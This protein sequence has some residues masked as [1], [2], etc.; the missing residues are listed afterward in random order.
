MST[1]EVESALVSHPNVAEA[2]A[3]GRPHELKG[4]AVAVFVT[5]KDVEPSD[6]LRTELKQHVRKE[7]R[8]RRKRREK[9]IK[10]R[11]KEA[12]VMTLKPGNYTFRITNKNV[13]YGLGFWLRG[14]GV[15]GR[16]TLPSVSGGG[17]TTG[18]TKDYEITL[19]PGKYY[20]SCPLNPTPDYQIVVEG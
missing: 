18:A 15:I 17:L 13:P 16:A 20:F 8:R 9:R 1:I 10:Q 4:E 6:E 19:K 7:I 2:A 12:K 14:Q 11:I 3:V 5:L